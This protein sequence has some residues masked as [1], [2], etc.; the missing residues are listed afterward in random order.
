MHPDR[1]YRRRGWPEHHDHHAHTAGGHRPAGRD[2]VRRRDQRGDVRGP[3]VA[4]GRATAVPAPRRQPVRRTQKTLRY[5][6]LL[7]FFLL[8]AGPLLWQ[9]SL[10]F[11]GAGDDLY[12]QP[13]Q[14]IPADPTTGNYTGVLDRLPVLRYVLNS[15]IVA[16]LV[17]AGNVA[18]GTLAGFALARLRFRFRG[19]VTG[20]FVVALLV[21]TESIIIAQFLLI[22]STGLADTLLGVAL[23]TCV[24]ALNVLLM[25]NGFQAIPAELEEA[26][27]IDGAGVWRRFWHVCVPQVRGVMT[28]VAIFSFVGAWNDFLWPLIV[29]SGEENYTLT[30]GLNRL[31]GTFYSDPRLIA[32]GTII[33]LLPILAVFALL[34]RSFLRGLEAGG[35]KG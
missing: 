31:R 11:K 15:G 3:R 9:L 25:R 29:L 24:A 6:V 12:A 21:P 28:V 13:P 1:R 30:L 27:R 35:I 16:L 14:V 19:L 20:L 17:V 26:A 8:L 22:R 7:A 34:Q 5:L 4:A 32:A 18:G 2:R 33:A 23:P 10:S